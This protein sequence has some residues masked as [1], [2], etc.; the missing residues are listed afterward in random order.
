MSQVTLK[1]LNAF[2]RLVWN[3]RQALCYFFLPDNR[4]LGTA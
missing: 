3:H 1:Q 2:Y 4:R